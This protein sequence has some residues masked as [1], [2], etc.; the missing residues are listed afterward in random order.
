MGRYAV[1]SIVFKNAPSSSRTRVRRRMDKSGTREIIHQLRHVPWLPKD[2]LERGWT[3]PGVGIGVTR[4]ASY[5]EQRL[6]SHSR[7]GFLSL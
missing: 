3:H 1:H 6:E 5:L 7:K 2:R 4:G